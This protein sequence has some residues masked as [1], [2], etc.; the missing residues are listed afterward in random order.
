MTWP[1]DRAE[2]VTVPLSSPITSAGQHQAPINAGI[3]KRRARTE[4][5]MPR[6]SMASMPGLLR[7][8]GTSRSRASSAPD[9][10]GGAGDRTAEDSGAEDDVSPADSAGKTSAATFLGL[11]RGFHSQF[12]SGQSTSRCGR[13]RA[14]CPSPAD[15]MLNLELQMLVRALRF[16]F[17]RCVPTKMLGI[18]YCHHTTSGACPH[19]RRVAFAA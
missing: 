6:R 19:T 15:G 16:R 17:L 14:S 8:L 5:S 13:Y 2:A 1:S 12:P 3:E 7:S 10:C 18:T 9:V 11:G 4:M